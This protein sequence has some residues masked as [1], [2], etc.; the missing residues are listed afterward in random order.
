MSITCTYD[1]SNPPDKPPKFR[2]NSAPLPETPLPAG[3]PAVDNNKAPPLPDGAPTT[4]C[5]IASVMNTFDRAYDFIE[6]ER[7][8]NERAM[9][10]DVIEKTTKRGATDEFGRPVKSKYDLM[11]ANASKREFL[12]LKQRPTR[13]LLW[14]KTGTDRSCAIAAA[15]LIRKFGVTLK[16]AMTLLNS[17][18]K[19]VVI[20]PL[21]MSALEQY[22]KKHVLGELLCVD[23]IAGGLSPET[24]FQNPL[25]ESILGQMGA[26]LMTDSSAANDGGAESAWKKNMRSYLT[27]NSDL[28]HPSRFTDN[29]P[30]HVRSQPLLLDLS[31]GGVNLR[32][33]GLKLLVDA[34]ISAGGAQYLRKIDLKNNGI[35]CV[36]CDHLDT[37]IT[38]GGRNKNDNLCFLDL[39]H[40]RYCDIIDLIY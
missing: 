20:Q 39:S 38:G 36:G 26:A 10:S 23:C 12:F 27:Y 13:V 18:R 2:G 21:F 8:Y 5:S 37:L 22:E 17:K 15:Y 7:I 35:T 40:N 6:L 31:I 30:A 24:N 25:F 16:Y 11:D 4:A 29:T 3:D 19:G 28:V 9:E 34:M 14:C 1:I 32:D 33:A